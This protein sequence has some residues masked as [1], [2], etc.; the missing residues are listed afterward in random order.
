M[1]SHGNYTATFSVTI[2]KTGKRVDFWP[3]YCNF[4]TLDPILS[5][6]ISVDH[7]QVKFFRPVRQFHE[8][9]SSFM[10]IPPKYGKMQISL[11]LS[12]VYISLVGSVTIADGQIEWR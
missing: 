12:L 5:L 6:E 8:K 2:R 9:T 1:V 4:S 11:S 3:F 7:S 10:V